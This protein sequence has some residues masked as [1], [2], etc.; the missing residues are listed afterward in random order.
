MSCAADHVVVTARRLLIPVEAT[1]NG[2]RDA[3]LQLKRLAGLEQPI[4][5]GVIILK[6]DDPEWARRCFVKL[7]DGAQ[8][9]LTMTITSYG[10]LPD[11]TFPE[12]ITPQW[13]ND[14]RV[15]PHELIEI[16]DMFKSDLENHRLITKENTHG[17]EISTASIG[18]P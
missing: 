14:P 8:S 1:L 16:A 5:V 6:S 10:Y 17:Q 7:A 9:F 3:Y 15:L 13:V 11:K 12:M 4:D 2:V 18:F